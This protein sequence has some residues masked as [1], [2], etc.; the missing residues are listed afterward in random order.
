MN[1]ELGRATLGLRREFGEDWRIDQLRGFANGVVDPTV[2]TA[3]NEWARQ[4]RITGAAA[5]SDH[6]PLGGYERGVH[7]FFEAHRRAVLAGDDDDI[8]F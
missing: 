5:F 8:P 1:H 6:E 2:R 7:D 3:V 4:H